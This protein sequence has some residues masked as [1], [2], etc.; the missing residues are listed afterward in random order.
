MTRKLFV[1][2]AQLPIWTKDWDRFIIDVQVPGESLSTSRTSQLVWRIR[3]SKIFY[4]WTDTRAEN[5]WRRG[6]CRAH[7]GLPTP[8]ALSTLLL[9]LPTILIA[10]PRSSSHPAA[11]AT[12][13]FGMAKG[14]RVLIFKK[15]NGGESRN[16]KDI[17]IVNRSDHVPAPGLPSAAP[18]FV[19]LVLP[20]HA[21]ACLTCCYHCGATVTDVDLFLSFKAIPID[22]ST[23]CASLLCRGTHFT[24][25]EAVKL[26]LKESL[27]SWGQAFQC[28]S[29]HVQDKRVTL[30]VCIRTHTLM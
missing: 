29:L 5:A 12:A 7:L 1:P 11:A 6:R 17:F 9:F 20:W 30:C 13:F 3:I 10:S 24:S 27:R 21:L 26:I 16:P 23:S 25:W 15:W 28:S 14:G 4:L 19:S 2:N 18:A 8:R 22:S